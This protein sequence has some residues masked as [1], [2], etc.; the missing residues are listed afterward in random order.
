MLQRINTRRF[1]HA[2]STATLLGATGCNFTEFDKYEEEAPIR[3]YDAPEN[4]PRAGG[5]GSVVTSFQTGEAPR[6]VVVASGGRDSPVVFERMW[7]GR[8]LDDASFIRC[9][10]KEDCKDGLGVGGALISF[11]SWALGTPQEES[12]CI[13]S[14]GQPKAYVFCDSNTNANQS[15]ELDVGDIGANGKVVQ[16]SGAGLPPRHPLGV[17]LFGAYAVSIRS[18][19]PSDGRIFAQPDF[20]PPGAPSDDDVVPPAEELRLMDPETGELFADDAAAGDLGY[21]LSLAQDE[22]GDLLIAVSQPSR[23][24]VIV[25]SYA[26]RALVTRACLESPDDSVEGFGKS[27]VVGDVNNDGQPEVIVGTDAVA[28]AERVWLYQ[29]A[30]L[31]AEDPSATRCASWRNSPV[32]ITCIEGIQDVTCGDSAF[33]AALALGDVDGDGIKDLLVG[34]PNAKVGSAVQAGAVWLFPGGEDS[35][36]SGGLDLERA[37]NL[38][39]N[40]KARAHLGAALATLRTKQR[41][42]P[43]AGAPGEARLYTFMCSALEEDVANQRL[44]LPK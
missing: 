33:G 25:A 43:V 42:E 29:G 26:N 9:K 24:R 15:F 40:N 13:F 30:G 6:S 14:P 8:G 38:F 37:T 31:P 36:R 18:G 3:V 12:G 35:A 7:T 32:E 23:K 19:E 39:A 41:D 11:P 44:C 16:F 34:A 4:Y 20:Q 10:R 21:A 2:L 1:L 22:N 5:Y 17:A 27:L 28:S